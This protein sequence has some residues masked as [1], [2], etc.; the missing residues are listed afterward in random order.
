M[1]DLKGIDCAEGD[2]VIIVGTDLPAT[3]VAKLAQ[4]ISYETLTAISHRIPRVI[5]RK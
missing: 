3:S 1:V 4:T 5:C 2:K